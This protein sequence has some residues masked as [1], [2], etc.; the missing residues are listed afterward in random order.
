MEMHLGKLP[1]FLYADTVVYFSVL[2]LANGK[3]NKCFVVILLCFL[4]CYSA[5]PITS[6]PSLENKGLCL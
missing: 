1:A 3:K 6:L 4:G 2:L 5:Y